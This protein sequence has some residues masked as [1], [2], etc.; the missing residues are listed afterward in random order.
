M[1][2]IPKFAIITDGNTTQAF[3]DGKNIGGAVGDLIYSARDSQGNIKP[4]LRLLD[5]DIRNFT[6]TEG[7]DLESYLNE[8]ESLHHM[9]N[10]A[11]SDLSNPLL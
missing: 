9:V 8:R 1:N 11:D 3:L 4:T 5:I 2:Y 6:L 7:K 10:G